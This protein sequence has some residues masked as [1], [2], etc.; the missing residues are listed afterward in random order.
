MSDDHRIVSES[1]CARSASARARTPCA[2][3][4]GPAL[5]S[6]A[7][8]LSAFHSPTR[9]VASS[10]AAN[11]SSASVCSSS[12]ETPSRAALSTRSLRSTCVESAETGAIPGPIRNT[13]ANKGTPLT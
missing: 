1:F 6:S 3:I 4:K 5:H 11:A 2:S 10:A 9:A 12:V 8:M 7:T 13:L